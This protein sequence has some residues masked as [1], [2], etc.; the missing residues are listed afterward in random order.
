MLIQFLEDPDKTVRVAQQE[1]E[2]RK[3]HNA[4]HWLVTSLSARFE[5]NE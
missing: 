5:K 1:I 2:L 3:L 4:I